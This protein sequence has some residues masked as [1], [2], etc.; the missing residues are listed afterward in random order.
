MKYQ[1]IRPSDTAAGLVK[2]YW[3]VDSERGRRISKEKIIPDG[4]P[5]LILHFGDPYRINFGSRWETQGKRLLAGQI[6]KYFYLKNTGQSR[7]I[8][9]KMQPAALTH[10]YGIDMK[11]LVDRVMEVSESHPCAVIFDLLD[12]SVSFESNVERLDNYFGQVRPVLTHEELD[13]ALARILSGRGSTKI[14]DI[15]SSS[16]AERRRLERQFS[17]Y[18]GL[19]PKRY[20]RIVRLKNIFESVQ[21]NDASWGDVVFDHDYFD[22]AHFIRDFREFT[23]CSP[24]AYGFDENNFANFFMKRR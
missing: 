10:L 2:L 3:S 22:Q 14:N 15:A 23:G 17:R 7:M 6:T 4:Y 13:Q 8:G 9:I 19:S 24:S 12:A 18:V 5:E 11:P 16:S 1:E 21:G 20:S